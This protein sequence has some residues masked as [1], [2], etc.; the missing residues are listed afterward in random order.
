MATPIL[1]S[2]F[3]GIITLNSSVMDYKKI[4]K[5]RKNRLKILTYL[6]FLPDSVMLRLQYRIKMGFWPNFHNPKRFTEKM[7]LYKQEARARM[8]S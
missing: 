5:S 1:V 6:S 7:Q 2:C 8:H 4:F 3:Y